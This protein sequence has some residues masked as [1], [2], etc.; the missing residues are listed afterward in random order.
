MGVG[1]QDSYSERKLP[2]GRTK[3]GKMSEASHCR[4]NIAMTNA[5]AMLP[6][7]LVLKFRKQK[8]ILTTAR[9]QEAKCIFGG[10][11]LSGKWLS[12][13][14]LFCRCSCAW[15][16]FFSQRKLGHKEIYSQ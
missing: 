4:G 9:R 6:L 16:W 13:C 14:G 2:D 1:R 7:T 10:N 12:L 8:A 11:R 3:D 15:L 5:C